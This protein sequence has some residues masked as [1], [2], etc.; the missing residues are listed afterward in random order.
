MYAG[1]PPWGQFTPD[2]TQTVRVEATD[3][4]RSWLVTLGR[5]TGTDPDGVAHDEQDLAIAPSDDEASDTG[6]PPAATGRGAAADLDC[7]LWHRPPSGEVERGGDPL[8]LLRL[9]QTIATGIS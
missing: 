5:F 3:T 9:D 2:P 6:E 7:W 8:V 1:L 4:H